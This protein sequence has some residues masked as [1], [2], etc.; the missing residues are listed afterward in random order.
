MVKNT[1]G[2]KAK[3]LARKSVKPSGGGTSKLRMVE[4]EG[5][6]YGIVKKIFGG[7]MC[8]VLCDDLI[9][10]QGIIRGK[11][12]G[13][14]KRNNLIASG[15]VVILG[16]R[17]WSSGK[18]GDKM[19]QGDIL[20]V[21]SPLEV[22]QLKQKPNFPVSF[23]DDSMREIFGASSAGEKDDGFEFTSVEQEMEKPR[24]E[25]IMCDSG[26]VIEIDDI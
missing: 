25:I 19:E 1:G 13:K 5:E 15:T 10:R 24:D 6:K 12:R 2:N 4:D 14:G 23:L 9:P 8:E 21:Y 22:D 17:D 16:L 11:F 7:A 20:E 18:S 26:E 3:G